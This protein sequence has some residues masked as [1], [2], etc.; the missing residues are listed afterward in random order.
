MK[1]IILALMILISTGCAEDASNNPLDTP[2]ALTDRDENLDQK[3]VIDKPDASDVEAIVSDESGEALLPD[4]DQL[5]QTILEAFEDVS[6]TVWGENIDGVIT[7]IDTDDKVVTLTF[8]ACDGNP[9]GYDEALIDFL[10]EEQIPATLFINAKWIEEHTDVFIDLANNPLF[11]IA[12]HG[13]DH[14]PLSVT[15]EQAYGMTGT[16][17]VEEVFD[18]I[19]KNQL[20]ITELIGET[21]KYFRSGTA[22]YDDVAVEII[23]EMGLTAVNYNVLGDAGGTFNKNQIVSA[24]NSAEEGA[25]FLFHMNK[26][27]SDISH[28]VIEGVQLLIDK[29][30]DFVQLG[31][32]DAHLK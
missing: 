14:K 11:E 19:Y 12:N 8:D 20:L 28:G 29:G 26:P 24:F 30:Y 15:G 31:E 27:S 1:L 10:I 5:R 9:N 18:E 25:I 13:H 6:P 4:Y 17:N 3:Q 32:Y 22:Y 16:Q 7:E 2:E 23:N 21:P